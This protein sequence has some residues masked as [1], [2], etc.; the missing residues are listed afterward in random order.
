MVSKVKHFSA[1]SDPNLACVDI[2][3]K[4]LVHQVIFLRI[5]KL[6]RVASETVGIACG[7]CLLEDD[8]L[9]ADMSLQKRARFTTPTGRFMVGESSSAD[10]ARQAGHTLAHTVDYGFIDTMDASICTS[11]SRAMT[12]M[13]VVNK[14]VT[15][16]VT[17]QRQ[18]T[19]ELQRQ[20][21]RDED[22]L[23]SHIQHKHDRFRELVRTTEA[24][25]QDGPAGAGSSFADALA[26]IEANR[27]SRNGDDSHDLRTGSRRTERP[28]RKCTYS[29]FLKCQPLNFKGTKGVIKFATCTFLGSALTWWNSHVKTVGH[30]D[31][32]VSLLCP[33]GGRFVRNIQ[34]VCGA[35][36]GAVTHPDDQVTPKLVKLVQTG[37]KWKV[38]FERHKLFGWPT[39]FLHGKGYNIQGPFRS[40]DE[41]ITIPDE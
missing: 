8:I 21:I 25:P 24:G 35:L 33:V 1:R 2:V 26:E 5:R 32:D 27:P 12:T 16:F 10:A 20:R 13:G 22:R 30:D 29:D 41:A 23:T 19:H 11:E 39:A 17:T 34:G 36:D 6:G 31:A 7:V 40:L 4:L 15:N 38:G 37:P 28:A 18:E 14:R 9:E 3:W